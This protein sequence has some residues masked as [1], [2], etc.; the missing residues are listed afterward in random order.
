MILLFT[1]DLLLLNVAMKKNSEI[2]Q[3]CY[4]ANNI[5][6]MITQEFHVTRSCPVPPSDA[7]LPVWCSVAGHWATRG[8]GLSTRVLPEQVLLYCVAGNGYLVFDQIRYEIQ[9]GDVVLC[10]GGLPHAYGCLEEGWEIYWVHFGGAQAIDLCDQAHL[11]P[12]A[13][14]RAVG[15][16]P[17]LLNAFSTLVESLSHS[18]YS[19]PWTASAHLY[20]TLL[21]LINVAQSRADRRLADLVTD[22]CCSLDDLVARSG[23]SKYHFIR[24]FKEETGCSPWQYVIERRLERARELLLGTRLSV[25]E[26]AT[27]LGFNTPDYFA[28]L[29]AKQNGVTPSRYRGR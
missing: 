22:D 2:Q 14:V 1:N 12:S 15:R 28:R 9:S 17:Q 18:A 21:A 6:I 20:A 19:S 5:A 25:K 23:Y 11:T 29:F 3:N 26:I 8:H 27:Q 24:I 7:R 4:K 16:N 13:P 10:P